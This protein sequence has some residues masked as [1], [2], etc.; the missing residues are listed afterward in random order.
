[1]GEKSDDRVRVRIE[2]KRVY[3]KEKRLLEYCRMLPGGGSLETSMRWFIN[4][5]GE[6]HEQGPGHRDWWRSTY[7]ITFD[8]FE[9]SERERWFP[10]D[11]E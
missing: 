1:M 8:M 11:D 3:F 6:Y 5:K 9:E 4:S 2:E 10:K 7:S